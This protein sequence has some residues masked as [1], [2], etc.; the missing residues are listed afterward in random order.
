MNIWLQVAVEASPGVRI[1]DSCELVDVVLEIQYRSI[2]RPPH[3]VS[4]GGTFVSI[5][6]V[7]RHIPQTK[8]TENQ[9]HLLQL[10][11]SAETGEELGLEECATRFPVP[12]GP[13]LSGSE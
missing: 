7:W 8:T 1:I 11:P 10:L 6:F 5:A 4:V 2:L 3:S 13:K 9:I 12:L